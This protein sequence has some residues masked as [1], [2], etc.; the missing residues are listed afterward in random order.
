MSQMRFDSSVF[1]TT[2]TFL[3]NSTIHYYRATCAI[4]LNQKDPYSEQKQIRTD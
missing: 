2:K 4:K 1:H 3:T